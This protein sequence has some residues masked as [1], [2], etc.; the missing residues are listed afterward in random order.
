M[1]SHI[2][3]GQFQSDKYPTTPPGKVPLSVRDPAAQDLLWEYARRR[4]PV[5]AEFSADLRRALRDAGY[6]GEGPDDGTGRS[7]AGPVYFYERDYYV[8]SNFSSF[9]LLWAGVDFPA[10]EYAYHWEKFP[11]DAYL[12]QSIERARSAH[13]AFQLARAHDHRRRP[14][15]LD[16]RVPLMRRIL[17]AKARQHRYVL[18]K[19][20]ATGD[21]PLVENSWRDDFWGWGADRG[22]QNTLGRLWE[23]VRAELAAEAVAQEPAPLGDL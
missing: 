4:E 11:G 17:V 13:E 3:N 8:L 6:A 16:V 14:D 1:G 12:R 18:G 20:L 5:D 21:R 2:V 15:W 22:G 19:L 23:E 9:R 10:A 7:T